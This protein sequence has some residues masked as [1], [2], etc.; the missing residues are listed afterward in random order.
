[1]VSA[2]S[3]IILNVIVNFMCFEENYVC[4]VTK[5]Y[6]HRSWVQL[7]HSLVYFYCIVGTNV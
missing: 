5:V 7:C 3:N 1:M 2:I 6:I 4:G